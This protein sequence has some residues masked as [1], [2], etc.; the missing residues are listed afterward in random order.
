MAV[1]SK[2]YKKLLERAREIALVSGAAETLGWDTETYMPPK[3]LGFRAEELGYLGG[4]AHRLF[5]A[6]RVGEWIAECEQHG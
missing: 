1:A 2:A 3:A 4:H 6:R 5:T